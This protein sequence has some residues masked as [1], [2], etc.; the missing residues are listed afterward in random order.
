MKVLMPFLNLSDKMWGR[1]SK[2]LSA[3]AKN[4]EEF[5]IIYSNGKPPKTDLFNFYRIKVNRTY[6]DFR[7]RLGFIGKTLRQ[8][9]FWKSTIDVRKNFSDIDLVYSLSGSTVPVT[10]NILK[11][12]LNCPAICRIRGDPRIE[13]RMIYN[14]SMYVNLLDNLNFNA[15]KSLNLLVP[16]SERIRSVIISYGISEEKLSEPVPNGIDV[17]FFRP[18]EKS[19]HFT[20]G[21]AGRIS[22]EKGGVFLQKLMERTPEVNYLIAGPVQMSWRPPKNCRYL[23]F[24]HHD[25][26]PEFFNRCSVII[27]PS[28]SEGL[29]NTLLESYACCVPVI[30]TSVVFPHDVKMFGYT[31]PLKLERWTHTIR[32]LR[33][34]ADELEEIG[35]NAREY[36]KR[37]SWDVYG[38]KMISIFKQVIDDK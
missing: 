11:D 21:Y 13:R 9:I 30:G 10:T 6:D 33:E 16:I 19:H 12:I 26:M 29:S 7:V 2:Q 25:E 36:V 34:K 5:Y 38:D 37:F 24:V 15:L 31:L 14:S 8:I 22:P 32:G 20:V 3:L 27:M 35:W 4:V 17:S 18:T 1:Y 23:G 28:V